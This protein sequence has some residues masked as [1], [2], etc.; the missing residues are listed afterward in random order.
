[1]SEMERRKGILRAVHNCNRE[2]VNVQDYL[3]SEYSTYIE[4]E[5]EVSQEVAFEILC[6]VLGEEGLDNPY[7][8]YDGVLYK[9]EHEEDIDTFGHVEAEWVYRDTI[10]VDCHWYNGGGGFRECV[11]AA[12]IKLKEDYNNE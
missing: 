3:E 5:E 11:D 2:Y 12:L 1:M 8:L 7:H 6:T 9:L 10:K 4:E